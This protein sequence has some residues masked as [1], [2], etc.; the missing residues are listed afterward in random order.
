MKVKGFTVVMEQDISG[1]HAEL[2][3]AAIGALRGVL[4]VVPLEATG[5][6]HF[7]EARARADLGRKLIEV[8][9]P[10]RRGS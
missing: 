8:V 1:E 3:R 9:Y 7:A 4:E 2:L 10:A 6:D 5:E